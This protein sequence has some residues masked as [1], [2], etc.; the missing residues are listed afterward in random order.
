MVPTSARKYINII[1]YTH[2][3]PWRWPNGW[4]KHVEVHYLYIYIHNSITRI[5]ICWYHYCACLTNVCGPHY[6]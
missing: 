4:P 3:T 1:L 5:C 6:I 2:W